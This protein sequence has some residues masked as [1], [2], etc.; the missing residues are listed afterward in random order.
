MRVYWGRWDHMLCG[1]SLLEDDLASVAQ[2]IGFVRGVCVPLNGATRGLSRWGY[3]SRQR[4][5]PG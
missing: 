2:A 3:C 5:A 1:A 4:H